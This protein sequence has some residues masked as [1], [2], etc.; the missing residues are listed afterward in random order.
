VPHAPALYSA[1][2]AAGLGG[3][4]HLTTRQ[5]AADHR[6]ILAE[7]KDRLKPENARPCRPNATSL[8]E[9]GVDLDFPRVWRAE[10]G[11]DQIAQARGRC[12]RE[13]RKLINDSIVTVF[14]PAEAKPPREI[15]GFITDMERMKNNHGNDP[16]SPEAMRDCFGEVYWHKG[17]LGLDCI[18]AR[19]STTPTPRTK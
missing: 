16:L 4:I 5:T 6:A 1:V 15:E 7:V 17:D 8:V 3:A 12:Y 11:L 18:R 13:G 10:A 19:I 2:R 14:H 9:A